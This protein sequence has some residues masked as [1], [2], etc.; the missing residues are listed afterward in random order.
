MNQGLKCVCG[1]IANKSLTKSLA[2][3]VNLAFALF[4]LQKLQAAF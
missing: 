2:F 4:K 3:F 1:W